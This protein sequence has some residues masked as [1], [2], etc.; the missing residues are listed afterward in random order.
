MGFEWMHVDEFQNLLLKCTFMQQCIT[1]SIVKRSNVNGCGQ[2]ARK[3]ISL[4]DMNPCFGRPSP[5]SL[6]K[7]A[8]K[9]ALQAQKRDRLSPG[10]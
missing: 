4:L 3:L 9:F 6:V 1:A 5:A 2:Q 7:K 10:L 8:A